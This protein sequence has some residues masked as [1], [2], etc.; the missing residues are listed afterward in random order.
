MSGYHQTRF[1]EDQR[2]DVLWKTLCESHF[3]RLV[4]EADSVL[5]LGCGYGGFI[6]NIQCATKMA[7]DQWPGA[8]QYLKS[9]VK[10]Q[11]GNITDL[12]T[13]PDR[14]ID[15][16]FSSNVFEHLPRTEFTAC[17][18]EV[19]RV[20]R[21]DGTINILQPNY[22][23][24]SNEYFDDYT[25]VSVYSDRSMCDILRASGFRILECTPR[26]LPLTIKSRLPVWPALI[27]AYL[28]SPIK[29][30]GKQ[31]FIRASLDKQ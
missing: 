17:I 12:Q 3:Q 20:L 18:E 29:L 26:F 10:I 22:R 11:I 14:S 15:F 21:A 9:D 1:E 5:D 28:K 8:A 4:H 13:I 30:L 2:R 6:N 27:R 25:H 24:C 23:F 31:M 19:K 16:V 7:I